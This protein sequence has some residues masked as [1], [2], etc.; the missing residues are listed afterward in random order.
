MHR[1]AYQLMHVDRNCLTLLAS[2]HGPPEMIMTPLHPA[3]ATRA[4]N[5]APNFYGM[6]HRELTELLESRGLD[7]YRAD[8]L[9]SW[10]YHKHQ[11]DPERMTNLPASAARRSCGEL[12]DL[13][14]PRWPRSMPRRTDGRTSSCSGSAD[15]ARVECVSMRTDAPPH[16]LPLEPGGLRAQVQLLRDRPDGAHAQPARPRR[17]SLR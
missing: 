9:F 3:P 12:C 16:L 11:R 10:V 7:A 8:Q 6:A 13:A 1:Y 15:G 14:C 5:A 17:S 4:M 2:A